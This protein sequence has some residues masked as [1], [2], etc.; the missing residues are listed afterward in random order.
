MYDLV[1]ELF[2]ELEELEEYRREGPTVEEPPVVLN[3]D[4][5]R[6]ERLA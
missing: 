6:L 3:S 5:S 1:N 2:Q 4:Q